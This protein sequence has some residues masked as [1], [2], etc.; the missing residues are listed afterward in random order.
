MKA[1]SKRLERR[2]DRE[3]NYK[4]VVKVLATSRKDLKRQLCWRPRAK[5]LSL[6]NLFMKS[7]KLLD[8]SLQKPKMTKKL[9]AW[10]L[11]RWFLTHQSHEGR[12]IQQLVLMELSHQTRKPRP[13]DCRKNSTIIADNSSSGMKRMSRNVR[14]SKL[15]W[16]R[17]R[18]ISQICTP[19]TITLT[20]NLRSSS[21]LDRS[22]SKHCSA[23]M[24][25][26]ASGKLLRLKRNCWSSRKKR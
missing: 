17:N 25:E 19:R 11:S 8:R 21:K 15:H 14:N 4:R 22:K 2:L 26:P 24:K 9:R 1:M 5:L 3:P 23:W 12:K 7:P 16:R 18:M 6:V 13:K 10:A 20:S